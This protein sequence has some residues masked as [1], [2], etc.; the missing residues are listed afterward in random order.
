M[1]TLIPRALPA[2]GTIGIISPASP[3]NT[4]S[5]VLARYLHGG[6]PEDIMLS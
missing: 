5:D 1:N 6:K 2:G 4:Y 3:Y